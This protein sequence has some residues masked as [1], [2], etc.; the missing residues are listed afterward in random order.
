MYPSCKSINSCSQRQQVYKDIY[1]DRYKQSKQISHVSLAMIT[2][3]IF[4]KSSSNLLQTDLDILT[5]CWAQFY[6]L[7]PLWGILHAMKDTVSHMYWGLV[8]LK[9][10]LNQ[11]WNA[12][13]VQSTSFSSYVYSELNPEPLKQTVD[14][15]NQTE[16]QRV[17][18]S[19]DVL[20]TD[21]LISNKVILH[22]TSAL[23]YSKPALST[24]LLRNYFRSVNKLTSR[25]RQ[26]LEQL[27]LLDMT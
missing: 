18:A 23:V 24:S 13:T 12:D 3:I 19:F 27:L 25:L 22:L 10:F 20:L 6:H 15:W 7:G 16:R 11:Y 9:I 2:L 8:F 17:W 21:S 26:P 5:Y 1:T 14:F 4:C